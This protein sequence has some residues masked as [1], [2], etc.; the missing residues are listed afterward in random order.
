MANGTTQQ[1]LSTANT[2]DTT[3]KQIGTESALSNYVGPYVTEMLGKGQAIAEMPYETYTGPLTAGES[4]LQTKAFTGLAGLTVPTDEMGTFTPGSF[5]DAGTADKYMN[6]Y[7][8]AALQPQID[9]ANRQAELKRIQDAGRLTKAGA[10]GGSRQ[11]IMESTGNRNLLDNIAKITGAG[12]R[13][14]YDKAVNQFNVEQN[15][16]AKAQDAINQYGLGTLLKMA[17]VGAAER[18][19]ESEGIAADREQFEE[20]RDYPYKAIQFMQSLL[21][22]LP[23][24]TQSYQYQQPSDLTN[25][26]N[27]GGG[28]QQFYKTLFPDSDVSDLLDIF[29]SDS[30]D[31]NTDVEDI[32]EDVNEVL[33]QDIAT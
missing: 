5:T 10:F 4:D 8:T 33:D 2:G 13:D 27:M 31:L 32:S 29:Q 28:F 18:G 22:G 25:L 20:E 21:Q 26:L 3:G 12:Y 1:P 7:L 24:A 9:E 14:A 19:I 16:A 6:P 30:T 11:A 17:D 23:L 15:M